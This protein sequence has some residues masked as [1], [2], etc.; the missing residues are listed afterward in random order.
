MKGD[1]WSVYTLRSEG[2]QV[3]EHPSAFPTPTHWQSEVFHYAEW[4]SLDDCDG[5]N[6]H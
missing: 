2:I 1:G 6:H 3:D 4:K 5:I